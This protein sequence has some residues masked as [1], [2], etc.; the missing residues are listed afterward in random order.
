MPLEDLED[1]DEIE[2]DLAP[3]PAAPES[4]NLSASPSAATPPTAPAPEIV[5]E[6]QEAADT[7]SPPDI[8]LEVV[9]P[10]AEIAPPAEVPGPD[11]PQERQ[12]LVDELESV[13]PDSGGTDPSERSKPDESAP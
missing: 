3:G 12:T 5:A 13:S 1:L 7:Q 10:E 8:D 9:A 4:Q 11:G 6:A 2:P